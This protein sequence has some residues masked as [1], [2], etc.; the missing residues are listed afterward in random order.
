MKLAILRSSSITRMRIGHIVVHGPAHRFEIGVLGQR[1]ERA[2]VP[3]D[4][5]L[6]RIANPVTGLAGVDHDVARPAGLG[7]RGNNHEIAAGDSRR[8]AAD[9]AV[10][11]LRALEFLARSYFL[12]GSPPDAVAP[13]DCVE[14]R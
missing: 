6:H 1:I 13:P 11:N 12:T 10:G 8:G 3:R 14:P 9:D 7:A 5:A 2:E 4:R